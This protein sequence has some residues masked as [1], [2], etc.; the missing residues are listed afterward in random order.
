MTRTKLQYA[1]ETGPN[2]REK[3]M[4]NI[5]TLLISLSRCGVKRVGVKA[6]RK[7]LLELGLN[8]T[9]YKPNGDLRAHGDALGGHGLRLLYVGDT[10]MLSQ[11]NI[12][13]CQEYLARIN[14]QLLL[15]I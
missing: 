4:R 2:L 7:I 3:R 10:I 12:H 1:Q 11:S 5:A 13:K 14:G 15:K 8:K 9:D 6:S